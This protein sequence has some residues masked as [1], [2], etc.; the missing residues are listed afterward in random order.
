MTKRGRPSGT[1][2]KFITDPDRFAVAFV[3]MLELAGVSQRKA[4]D[5]TTGIFFGKM[6][7][8]LE[9]PNRAKDREGY[10]TLSFVTQST[11]IRGKSSTIRKKSEKATSDSDLNWRSTIAGAYWLAFFRQDLP[12][13][14]LRDSVRILCTSAGEPLF[15]DVLLRMIIGPEKL[16]AELFSEVFAARSVIDGRPTLLQSPEANLDPDRS[17]RPPEP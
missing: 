14:Q 12:F 4:L 11:T 7:A 2:K 8:P 5:L 13:A 3:D 16:P 15:A 9:I 6:V 1:T 10:A 17:R